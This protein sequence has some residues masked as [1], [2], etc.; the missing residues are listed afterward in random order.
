MSLAELDTWRTGGV[1]FGGEFFG[2]CN[3]CRTHVARIAVSVRC[4]LCDDQGK[5]E[6]EWTEQ[7]RKRRMKAGLL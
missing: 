4:P 2:W 7:E 1:A 6:C 5:Y 3:A